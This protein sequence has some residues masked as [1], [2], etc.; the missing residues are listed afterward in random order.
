VPPSL[1][2]QILEGLRGS[3]VLPWRDLLEKEHD[4]EWRNLLSGWSGSVSFSQ[5]FQESAPQPGNGLGA[6]GERA[7]SGQLLVTT[8]VY[9]PVGSWFASVT[10]YHY[11]DPE[12][13]ASW[14]PDF[15]YSFG[16]DDW[17]PFALS[18]VYSNAGGNRWH[19]DRDQGERRTRFRQGSWSLG[20]KLRLPPAAERI[21][22]VPGGSLG[23]S[24]NLSVTPEYGD[25]ATGRL[26]HHKTS[27]GL[28]CKYA[29]TGWLF[30]S[31]KASY[32][33]QRDQQ[34][35]WDSDFTYGFGFADWH[36]GSFSVQLNNASGNRFPGRRRAVGT[37][38]L[39]DSGIT[40]SYS[41][42]Y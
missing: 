27:L 10:A 23:C 6:E 2:E 34:Q 9:R 30:F 4:A 14:N 29:L 17:H 12:L 42:S 11:F 15:T 16:Y 31:F 13:Q 8:V 18:L 24:T 36:P 32:Y 38:R 3:F 25:L 28:G 26:R 22:V 20:W 1:R 35:P 5:P 40:V 19:P 39:K 41:W 33:P 37:G 7:P 21:V